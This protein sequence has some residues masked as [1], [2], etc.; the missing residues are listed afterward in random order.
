MKKRLVSLLLA[1]LMIFTAVPVTVMAA[2][3]VNVAEDPVASGYEY[4][5]GTLLLYGYS[6]EDT[7]IVPDG[8]VIE[9]IGYNKVGSLDGTGYSITGSGILEVAGEIKGGEVTVDCGYMTAASITANDLTVK[10]G[11]TSVS[12]NVS[13]DEIAVSGGYLRAVGT[14]TADEVAVTGGYLETAGI[15]GN[16]SNAGG[17]VKVSANGI[18]GDVTASGGV[19]VVNNSTVA[20]SGTVTMTNG[21]KIFQ[22]SNCSELS[23]LGSN[24]SVVL[25]KSTLYKKSG[26]QSYSGETM[27]SVYVKANLSSG[28][29]LEL[30]GGSYVTGYAEIGNTSSSATRHVSGSG[31]LVVANGL[32]ANNYAT[33]TTTGTLIGI[34]PTSGSSVVAGIRLVYGTYASGEFIGVSNTTNCAAFRFQAGRGSYNSSKPLYILNDNVRMVAVSTQ[35]SNSDDALHVNSGSGSGPAFQMNGGSLTCYSKKGNGVEFDHGAEI[36]GG[37]LS[38]V[39]LGSYGYG[40]T[41]TA[42]TLLING[43]EIGAYGSSASLGDTNCYMQKGS[44]GDEIVMNLAGSF[45]GDFEEYELTNTRKKFSEHTRSINN[46]KSKICYVG[47]LKEEYT[48]TYQANGGYDAADPAVTAYEVAVLEQEDYELLTESPFIHDAE[49]G[50]DVV[51]FGWSE[52]QDDTIYTKDDTAPV[53]IETIDVADDEEVFALWGLDVNENGIAD[54]LE[55][56]Y[57]VTYEAAEGTSLTEDVVFTGLLS[58]EAIPAAPD[59]TADIGFELGMWVLTEGEEG[60]DGTVGEVDLVYTLTVDP[61]YLIVYSDGMEGE[62]FEDQ[63]YYVGYGEATPEF[64]GIPELDGYTFIGWDPEV[65]P[66]VTGAAVYTAMWEEDDNYH[67]LLLLG[68]AGPNVEVKWLNTEDHMAY[69]IGRGAN[70]FAPN[71]TV[72][73]AEAATMFFR[74]MEEDYRYYYLDNDASYADVSGSAWYN[75]A[76]ATLE[77]AGVIQDTD[78]NGY[79]RPNEP[80][81][82]AEMAMMAAQFCQVNGSVPAA[83]F[84]DV[85]RSH[86]AAD[87]IALMQFAGFIEGH[88]GCYRPEDTLTRAECVTIINRMLK[89]GAEA[90]NMLPGM[91][92]FVDVAPGAWYY[93]AVQEAA[94]SHTYSRSGYN[95]TGENFKGEYWHTLEKNPNW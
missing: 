30:V 76:V 63:E 54:V 26:E 67:W 27:D 18:D 42:N 73:R 87:E 52:T 60:A 14:V 58:G 81:T 31:T 70:T 59:V 66:T 24:T 28:N 20:I 91:V 92:T 12:G 90:E 93:E 74:L 50:V 17:V 11:Y 43:G 65:E 4:A 69:I 9:V 80:I 3:T 22:E 48:L 37:S 84:Y 61:L 77:A 10:H 25:A 16:V 53:A 2:G 6:T 21:E 94:N 40:L 8:T 1:V 62:A 33:F 34:A 86:W 41:C 46:G 23:E 57:T 13:A 83:S 45:G 38:T 64:D 35:R 88:E 55:D 51:W 49:D 36:N 32:H 29:A 85:S 5:G 47:E 56:T 72:T 79:F 39:G 44:A 7:L 78:T 75:V 19:T 95:L 71:G 68:A 15:V 82:R 89:R